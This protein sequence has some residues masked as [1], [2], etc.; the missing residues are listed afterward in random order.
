MQEGKSP[1]T[2]SSRSYQAKITNLCKLICFLLKIWS[3][4]SEIIE[5]I[6]LRKGLLKENDGLLQTLIFPS[7]TSI[8]HL[9]QLFAGL[10]PSLDHFVAGYSWC[11][12]R[13]CEQ[14]PAPCRAAFWHLCSNSVLPKMHVIP[15]IWT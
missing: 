4:K 13:H 2:S 6:T 14:A 3:E 15:K 10:L 5:I 11:R 1:N 9:L 12:R 8:P 7:P